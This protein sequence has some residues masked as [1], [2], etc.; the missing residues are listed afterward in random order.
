MTTA[1]EISDGQLSQVVV[2][3]TRAPKDQ[4]IIP[5]SEVERLA[6]AV[7]RDEVKGW[8]T[9]YRKAITES[10]L[11]ESE[12]ADA[13]GMDKGN[14][15][16]TITGGAMQQRRIRAFCNAVGNRVVLQVAC[17]L[18]GCELRPLES[19]LERQNRELREKVADLER[20]R[21]IE[22]GLLRE[23]REGK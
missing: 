12:I 9:V 13:L 11:F 19:E 5:L 23:I 20:R 21:E 1:D 18:V 7:E 10:G 16:K 22:I 8:E 15:S 17:Y 14:F 4:G 6:A 3:L 2:P